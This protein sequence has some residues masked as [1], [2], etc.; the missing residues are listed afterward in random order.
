[1]DKKIALCLL[2]CD[3]PELTRRTVESLKKHFRLEDFILLHGD[4]SSSTPEN[5]AIAAAAGF[6]T[7][8]EGRTRQGVA[9]MWEIMV[10]AAWKN[11]AAWVLF[12]ENDWE[13]V[14]DFPADFVAGLPEEIYYVRF[15]GKYREANNKRPCNPVNK[16]T[17]IRAV[18]KPY[19]AGWET[20]SIHWAFP[21]N[22]TKI[23]QALFL[24]RGILSEGDAIKRS[25]DIFAGKV[26]RPTENY[27][28]HI[29]ENRTD[30]FKA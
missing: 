24:T 2:T 28:Y 5:C 23:N 26:I 12:Q 20:G 9:K 4:D 29:G 18:W 15:F 13:W 27:L 6:T 11:H 3:R 25:R 17:G 14:R 10:Q 8:W 7:I 1:M 19:A 22:I 16:A 21:G 30:G